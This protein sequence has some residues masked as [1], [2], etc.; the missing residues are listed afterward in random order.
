MAVQP[1]DRRL[2][3]AMRRVVVTPTFA[4]G[5]GVVVA[6]VL[7]YPMQT[8]FNYASPNDGAPCQV[9]GCGVG[10]QPGGQTA[11]GPTHR[12]STHGPGAQSGSKG[13][14]SGTGHTPAGGGGGGGGQPAAAAP[15]LSYQTASKA[16][17]GFNGTIVISF[18]P[19]FAHQHWRL[20]FSYPSARILKV[21]AGSNIHI[22]HDQHTALVASLSSPAHGAVPRLVRVSIEVAGRPGPPG[23]C[24]FNGHGCH[25]GG[26]HAG[27]KGPTGAQGHKGDHKPAH[28][29]HK[30]KGSHSRKPLTPTARHAG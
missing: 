30:P 14:A 13:S 16:H 23:Q 11:S 20:Q 27:Q 22:Q 28:G 1:P 15:Q 4:A 7:A 26:Q 5:L 10:S 17:W 2:G 8:V 21:S 29:S 6:A 18:K 19:K 24:S 25:F 12:F 9:A 3:A